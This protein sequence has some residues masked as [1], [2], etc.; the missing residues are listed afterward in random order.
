MAESREEAD[1]MK[2]FDPI[3]NSDSE[4]LILGTFPSV[5]SREAGFYYSHPRNAFWRIISELYS[6]GEELDGTES[7][8]AVLLENR[9]ALWDVCET[10][11][12]KNS[13]DSTI[14]RVVFN[15][16]AGFVRGTR[17]R[18]LFFN[19]AKAE[20]LFERYLRETETDI[21]LPCVRL[22]STSPANA[23]PFEK[24]RREWEKAL[25]SAEC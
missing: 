15:D 3:F 19:G 23:M 18:A 17:I 14:R 8:K 13:A 21:G 12:V 5:K 10:C 11:D 22:P 2:C 7:K 16:I 4:M 9:V 6:R 25:K 20:Q 24:K 1:A